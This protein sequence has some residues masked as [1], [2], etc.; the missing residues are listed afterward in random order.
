MTPIPV[1]LAALCVIAWL[2]LL[3][4]RGRFW[5]LQFAPRETCAPRPARVA[6][7]IP[8]RNEAESIG[9]AVTS[10]LNQ[11]FDGL[12]RII[13][14]DDGSTDGT[15]A[16]ARQA[17][18]AASPEVLTVVAGTSLSPGWTGKMWA[19]QQGIE[20]TQQFDPDFLLL[21]DADIVHGP[22]SIAE[23]VAIAETRRYDLV[24]CMVKLHCETI[25]ERLMIPAF[26]FFFLMLYPPRWIANDRRRTAG[27][28]GGCMLVTPSALARAG[29]IAAVANE[30][31]DD[32]ALACAVKRSGGR[33]WLGLTRSTRSIRHYGS[34]AEIERMIARTAFNQLH[35]STVFLLASVLG[36]AV[37]FLLPVALLFTGQAVP[38]TLAVFS[39]LLMAASYLPTVLLYDLHP[40]WAFTLPLT[41]FLYTGAT[42]HSALN[43]WTGRGGEWKGRTQ[44]AP[45]QTGKRESTF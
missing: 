20:R 35:H 16:I 2:Y 37:V 45:A 30:I 41:T 40:L 4:A 11:K 32:C 42:L 18:S 24:S 10:L 12:I 25:A 43:F 22:E 44:D 29:G 33:V 23:L 27:A 17:A 39:L 6:V 9:A 34:F 8:A 21:T 19:V 7:V 38:V 26:V 28:A 1:S 13:V 3:A 31:I 36:L 15:A 14:V 5:R